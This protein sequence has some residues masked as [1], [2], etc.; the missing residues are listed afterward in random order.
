[1]TR[2]RDRARATRTVTGM[3]FA[4]LRH[5]PKARAAH[6]ELGEGRAWA[7]A[8]QEK[9][10]RV[11]EQVVHWNTPE[12]A[13]AMAETL[14]TRE[15]ILRA[16]VFATVAALL[17]GVVLVPGPDN[18]V[19]LFMA[20]AFVLAAVITRRALDRTTEHRLGLVHP[21]EIRLPAFLPKRLAFLATNPRRATP[22]GALVFETHERLRRLVEENSAAVAELRALLE[23][24]PNDAEAGERGAPSKEAIVR[25]AK[26]RAA[27]EEALN[28]E[29]SAY[30]K[31]VGQA[32][33]A[34]ERVQADGDWA[35]RV[36][37]ASRRAGHVAKLSIYALYA[38]LVGAAA[39]TWVVSAQVSFIAGVST[40]VGVY[41]AAFLGFQFSGLLM[42]RAA[43]R[44]ALPRAPRATGADA[45]A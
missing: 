25:S 23:V 2:P 30:G 7:V 21:E 29:R 27:L 34:V 20:A 31:I 32:L 41:V 19:G 35:A 44:A 10:E 14:R 28:P 9:T 38:A 5:D 24:E 22:E 37:A 33:A 40:G 13:L 42:A 3:L 39:A 11:R 12:G 6:D 43:E 8:C 26:L 17:V 15:R 1:M 45:A 36:H 16:G 4:A 18:A